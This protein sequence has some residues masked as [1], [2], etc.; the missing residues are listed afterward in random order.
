MQIQ[1]PITP[2]PILTAAL[3]AGLA[4]LAAA[5]A[6]EQPKTFSGQL[7][8][9]EREILVSLPTN[10]AKAR[11][12]PA[13]FQ[14]LVDGRPRDVSRAEPVSGGGAAPWTVLV[15][16]DRVLASPGTAFSSQVTLADH[17]RDLTRLGS[18]EIAVAGP[19]PTTVL[20]PT[21][22]PGA[23]REKLAALADTSRLERDHAP[24]A[25]AESPTDL[26]VRQQLDRLLAFLAAHHPAGP[27]ILFLVAD[28]TDLS[29]AQVGI[30]T[31]SSIPP[32]DLAET[33]AAAFM[34]VARL[35]A[36]Q[37]WV[38]IPVAVHPGS[39]GSPVSPQSEID[40]VQQSAATSS[41]T[42]GPPPVM[43]SNPRPSALI[44]PGVISLSTEPRLATLRA[45]AD[46][47]A[48]TVIGYEVQLAP[49]FAELP[50]R[51]T[52]WVSEPETPADDHLHSLTVRLPGRKAEARAPLWLK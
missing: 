47:T 1:R 38:V 51:W 11:L 34:R 18:V 10:L 16:V 31:G 27:H 5:S 20:A 52:I 42:N 32:A 19:E 12:K 25:K 35:L 4:L 14:V 17:A 41:H 50:R 29:A 48:G 24:A 8:I 21:P 7:D 49:L 6:Q 13:D 37:R 28:G 43:P 39:P 40:L 23:V 3:L 46:T 36:A 44:Y 9:R 30:L 15:Y 26:Q 22:E 45:L 2:R 33:P